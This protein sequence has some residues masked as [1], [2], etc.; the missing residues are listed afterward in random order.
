[1]TLNQLKYRLIQFFEGHAQINQTVYADDFDLNAERNLLYPVVN[2][3]WLN[4]NINNKVTNHRYKITI[5]DKVDENLEGIEDEVF[6]DSMLI[7]EDFFSWLQVQEGF[8][9]NKISS[10][11]KFSDDTRDRVSGIVFQIE[12]AVVRPQNECSIPNK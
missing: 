4:S 12:L 2:L 8:N 10:I 7:A 6:S 1:M 9:F 5:G 11:Q 3:E